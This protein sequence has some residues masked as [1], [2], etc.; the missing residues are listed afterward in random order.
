MP[1]VWSYWLAFADRVSMQEKEPPLS[2][3]FASRIS[4]N[5][6]GAYFGVYL[7]SQLFDQFLEPRFDFSHEDFAPILGAPDHMILA[8]IDNILV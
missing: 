2:L 8:G 3:T 7:G 1:P 6:A 4:R 5:S